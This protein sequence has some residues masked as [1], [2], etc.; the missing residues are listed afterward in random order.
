MCLCNVLL[1]NP[2]VLPRFLKGNFVFFKSVPSSHSENTGPVVRDHAKFS[3]M[4][5]KT[6]LQ[7]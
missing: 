2:V 4:R 5:N 3:Q 1:R 7:L 6:P